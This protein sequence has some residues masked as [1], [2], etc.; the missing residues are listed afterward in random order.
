MNKINKTISNNK[1]AK[2]FDELLKL[3]KT[4]S[5]E[6]IK[7]LKLIWDTAVDF[8]NWNSSDLI[9]GCKIT[10]KKLKDKFNLT[11]ESTAVLVRLASYD[12][13]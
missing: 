1:T 3:S 4:L 13:K 9:L 11:N 8:N 10:H 7:T 12:W 6:D 2:S 5:D